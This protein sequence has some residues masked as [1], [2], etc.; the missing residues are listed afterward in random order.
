MWLD[1]FPR[2]NLYGLDIDDFST[3]DLPRT[4]IFQGDQGTPQDLLAVV[5]VASNFDIIIDDGSHASYH[6]Q[7]SLRTLFPFLSSGGIY[8]VEDLDEQPHELEESLPKVRRTVD[9]LKD[10]RSLAEIVTGVS[11]VK[12]FSASIFTPQKDRLGIIIKE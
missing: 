12:L 1:Y 4:Q 9:I 10:V 7:T 8:I 2:A 11:D 5:E 3:V 6:Q